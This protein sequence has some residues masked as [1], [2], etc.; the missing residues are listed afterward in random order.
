MIAFQYSLTKKN[1]FKSLL[2]NQLKTILILILIFTFCYFAINLEAFLYN[3][4]LNTP[5]VL[6]T[7]L[8]YFGIIFLIMFLI[9]I[10]FSVI[11]TKMFQKN[12]A[13][14]VYKY[15]INKNK[16]IEKETNFELNLDEIKNIRINKKMI[17]FI[18]F[19]QRQI[20]TLEK[21]YF[22]NEDDFAKLRNFLKKK[23]ENLE[24]I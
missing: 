10:I 2:K 13:Y 8:I 3:F 15:Q 14:R 7:Y 6:I 4:P 9:S 16:L 21:V 23:K 20:I 5:L 12:H 17:K 19:K 11:M 24:L 22:E 18:S 1:H